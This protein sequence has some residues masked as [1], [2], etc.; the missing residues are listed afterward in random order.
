MDKKWSSC[1]NGRI[2]KRLEAIQIVLVQKNGAAPGNVA[3][4]VSTVGT[5][6]VNRPE[7]ALPE[8]PVSN[9]STGSN[10]TSGSTGSTGANKN[11][12]TRYSYEIVP[13]L[14]PFNEYFYVKTN[15]PDVSYV[16][17]E[18]KTVSIR[19]EKELI[20]SRRPGDFRCQIRE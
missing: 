7:I 12:V 9:G 1:W 15:N 11:D 14:E 3:G 8:N 18:D 20:L 4:I 2:C 5:G 13:L 10:G 19:P 6:F 16:R 17:F